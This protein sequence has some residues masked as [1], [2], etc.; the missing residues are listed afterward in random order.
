MSPDDIMK[1]LAAL[2]IDMCAECVEKL[3]EESDARKPDYAA[4]NHEDVVYEAIHC[5]TSSSVQMLFEND[6][7]AFSVERAVCTVSALKVGDLLGKVV[8]EELKYDMD[9]G[10]VGI[11]DIP[12]RFTARSASLLLSGEL[13]RTY[14]IFVQRGKKTTSFKIDV[15]DLRR[16]LIDTRFSAFSR[17]ARSR[18]A[19]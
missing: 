16:A 18:G 13:E 15:N 3:Q 19:P 12:S 11:T 10:L 6:S 14:N 4:F 2:G 5:L 8:I 17:G 7:Y 9:N 1:G